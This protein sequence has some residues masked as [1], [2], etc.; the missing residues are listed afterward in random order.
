MDDLIERLR[1]RANTYTWDS[2]TFY[3]SDAETMRQ[4]ADEIERLTA[5]VERRKYD[6][7]HTC[8]AECQREACVLRREVDAL[9]A[10]R[11]AMLARRTA[12]ECI[13]SK[14]GIRHGSSSFVPGEF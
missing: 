4:A 10:E 5:E 3:I 9:R 12:G 6:G 7:I 1:K 11:D 13:C 14:C 8:H 2:A